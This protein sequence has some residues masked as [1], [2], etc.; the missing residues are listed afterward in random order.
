MNTPT[1]LKTALIKQAEIEQQLARSDYDLSLCEAL[2]LLDA[3]NDSRLKNA[4][5]RKAAATLALGREVGYQDEMVV[6]ASLQLDLAKAKAEVEYQRAMLRV[7]VA[8]LE[9]R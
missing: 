3:A 9:G 2:A 6:N 7:E 4:E 8:A 5:S 1:A